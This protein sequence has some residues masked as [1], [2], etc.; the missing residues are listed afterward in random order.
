MI[1]DRE[2]ESLINKQFD[3]VNLIVL[4]EI[5]DLNKLYAKKSHESS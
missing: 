1:G 3:N 2:F 5:H 4:I